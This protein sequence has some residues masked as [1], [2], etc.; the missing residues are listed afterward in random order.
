MTQ[1]AEEQRVHLSN[2]ER[3]EKQGNGEAAMPWLDDIRK[4]GM[5][6]FE[7]VGYPS[8]RDEHWRH[9]QLGPIVRS[10][11]DLATGDLTDAAAD[12]ARDFG[13]GKEAITELVFVNGQFNPQLSSIGKLPRGVV[14]A[15]LAAAMESNDN[16]RVIRQ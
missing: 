15:S 5:S 4:A 1:L 10:K 14:A 3:F 12:A 11:F 8:P 7:L 2:F 6:Q 13:F 16:A 9:T